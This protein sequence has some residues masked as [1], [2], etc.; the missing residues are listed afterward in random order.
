MLTRQGLRRIKTKAVR[1]RVW[2]KTISRV[3]RG[4]VDL[5]LRCVESIRSPVLARVVSNIISKISRTLREGFMER[6]EK[7]GRGIAEKI[8]VLAER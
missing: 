1:Q 2:Y 7:A 5:T 8:C 6:A 3:E 4:I